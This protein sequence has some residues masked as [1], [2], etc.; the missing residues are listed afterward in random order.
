MEEIA[1]SPLECA[2]T[3]NGLASPLECA[4]TKSL[5]LKSFRIRSYEKTGWG[6]ARF[7]RPDVFNR[8]GC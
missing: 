1:L 3:K 8:E 6:E 5:D 2:V 7:V 4:V